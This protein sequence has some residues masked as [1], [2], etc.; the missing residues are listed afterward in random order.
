M[1]VLD[2][3]IVE[4]PNPQTIHFNG[5]PISLSALARETGVDNSYISRIFKGDRVPTLKV[6]HKICE[7]LGMGLEEFL[8][9]LGKHTGV[10]K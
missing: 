8:L 1:E 9:A 10:T 2:R 5:K 7:A 3:V 4:N 6:L